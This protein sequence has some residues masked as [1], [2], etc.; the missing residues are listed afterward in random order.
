MTW[1]SPVSVSQENQTQDNFTGEGRIFLGKPYLPGKIFLPI[2]Y[3]SLSSSSLRNQ[4]FYNDYKHEFQEYIRYLNIIVD[5][6]L[7]YNLQ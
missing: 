1:L 6:Y 7:I 4:L 3:S 2:L 5:K